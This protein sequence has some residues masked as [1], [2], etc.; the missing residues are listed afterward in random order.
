MT[1]TSKFGCDRFGNPKTSDGFTDETGRWEDLT[2]FQPDPETLMKVEEAVIIT[3][4]YTRA[5]EQVDQAKSDF[6]DE[7]EA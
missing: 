6:Y 1:C 4:S 2:S 5:G 7:E 3:A